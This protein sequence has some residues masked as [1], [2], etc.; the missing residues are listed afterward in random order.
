MEI[1]VGAGLGK[2]VAGAGVAAVGVT[3]AAV[4]VIGYGTVGGA[5]AVSGILLV[6]ALAIGGVMRGQNNIRV[7]R[8]IESRQTLL[9]I[10]LQEEEEKNLDIFFPLTPSPRQIEFI[11][12]DSQGDHTL[13]IDTQKALEGLHLAQAEK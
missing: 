7:N 10:V 3:G 9:P 5:A 2:L 4:A 11:Y 12:A 13:I 1:K 6:P 8:Q